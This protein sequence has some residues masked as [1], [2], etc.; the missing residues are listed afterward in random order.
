MYQNYDNRSLA[1]KGPWVWNSLPA[2]VRAPD[3]SLEMLRDKL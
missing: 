3:I 2:T 1:V